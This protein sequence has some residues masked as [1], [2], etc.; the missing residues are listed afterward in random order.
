M[1]PHDVLGIPP[2]A[3]TE[4][5]KAAYWKLAKQ[6]HPDRN[7]G[8]IAAAARMAEINLAKDAILKG[9]TW[10]GIDA[11][12]VALVVAVAGSGKTRTLAL[13]LAARDA[14]CAVVAGATI[15]LIG[16]VNGWL[17]KFHVS[18]P[19]TV[20]HSDQQGDRMVQQRVSP[21]HQRHHIC[22]VVDAVGRS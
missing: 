8:D 6:F 17:S 21:A 5:V 10:N 14:T 4:Q 11:L 20:I 16:E 12:V 1:S 15:R 13:D 22:A 3:T 19:V 9:T 7:P 2:D 18:V